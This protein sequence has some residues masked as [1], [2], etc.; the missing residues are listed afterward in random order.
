MDTGKIN[1]ITD[2]L[3]RANGNKNVLQAGTGSTISGELKSDILEVYRKQSRSRSSEGSCDTP[4]DSRNIE[5]ID[6]LPTLAQ[7]SY[8]FDSLN[9]HA[10]NFCENLLDY[11]NSPDIYHA[12]TARKFPLKNMADIGK[13][14]DSILKK[15]SNNQPISDPDKKVFKFLITGVFKMDH[16]LDARKSS[17][18]VRTLLLYFH[19]DKLGGRKTDLYSIIISKGSNLNK[20]I[21]DLWDIEIKRSP[22]S[23]KY[24]TNR[25]RIYPFSKS[26]TG[27]VSEMKASD[28]VPSQDFSDDYFIKSIKEL[29]RDFVTKHRW[30]SNRIGIE[31]QNLST[32]NQQKI[33]QEK[34][35]KV[36]IEKC[37]P[38]LLKILMDREDFDIKQL[39]PEGEIP[40]IYTIQLRTTYSHSWNHSGAV[41]K[42]LMENDINT[43][44]L[45]GKK[46]LQIAVE[47]FI[48][49]PARW[50]LSARENIVNLLLDCPK[51]CVDG[52]DSDGLTALCYIAK[53]DEID[54]RYLE[55]IKKMVNLG[56]NIDH[57]IS[58][59]ETVRTLFGKKLNPDKFAEL[60][61]L[62]DNCKGMK[63]K[64]SSAEI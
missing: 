13:F 39:K 46:P 22:D 49:C 40:L 56:A 14:F 38:D 18:I 59:H 36:I 35:L 4:I 7:N 50:I 21:N 64:G 23:S 17:K 32:L 30:R 28:Q 62:A 58:D 6:V 48:G 19:P 55:L 37:E 53:L 24:P 31:L 5:I 47:N 20:A 9:Q 16:N 60:E 43:L 42:I 41:I 33:Y 44:G 29:D 52:M 57:P 12:L 2:Y 34:L 10:K 3:F 26:G 51:L 11:V 8:F 63:R 15:H 25:N 61:T 45:K 54:E 1:Q 27:R